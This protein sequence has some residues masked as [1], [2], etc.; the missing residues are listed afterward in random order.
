MSKETESTMLL[1]GYTC[2]CPLDMDSVIQFPQQGH[3]SG[4]PDLVDHE[5]CKNRLD[6]WL[7]ITI[8]Q[9]CLRRCHYYS[10]GAYHQH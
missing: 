10:V 3:L 9:C 4:N 2:R 1:G 7:G 6:H 8:H 5:L